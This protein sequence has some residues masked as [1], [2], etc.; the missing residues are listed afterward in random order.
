MYLFAEQTGVA[1]MSKN[2]KIKLLDLYCGLGGLS[3]GFEMTGAYDTLGGID[4]YEWA[5][6]TFY[7]NHELKSKLISQVQD[8]SVLAPKAV[9]DDLGTS[10]DVIVGGP[11]CQGFSHAGRRLSDLEHDPRNAQ[12]FHFFRFV[13]EIRPRAFV[14]ENVSGILR[15]GQK[16]KNEL[17]ER[18]KG[19][20][21]EVGYSIS[22]RILNSVDYRVPQQRKRLF[23]VGILDHGKPFAFP[24]P[25]C[26]KQRN[27]FH[28]R[29]PYYTAGDALDDLPSPK[30]DEPQDYE[31]PPRTPMQRFLRNKSEAL[32]NHLPT[33]HREEMIKKI[34]KQPVGTRL[35]P[36]WNHSWY[37]LDP[38]KPS[39]A[40]KENHRAPFVH[41][42]ENRSA[43]PRECA[44]LQTIP[45]SYV[46]E[47][48]KTAQLIQ[49]GNA[50]PPA[51]AAHIAT[52]LASQGF[53]ISVP[54]PWTVKENPIISH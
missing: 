8:M 15:T 17:L 30:D 3:L 19:L 21:H 24:K 12:V 26:G 7:R 54:E 14:M 48:T 42:S 50:V 4:N 38:T 37:R 51:M 32:H 23:L 1:K 28:S 13:K 52:E 36:S 2:N 16:K 40:V 27:L 22:W 5:I 49:T 34:E 10:P 9:L 53:N 47:G 18:L 35:Y 46:L 43:S 45:D 31:K 33:K 25:C 20:Y 29:E 6:K 44:R 39:P 11:P 41:F